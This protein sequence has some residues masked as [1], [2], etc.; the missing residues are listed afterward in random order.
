MVIG[1]QMLRIL[2]YFPVYLIFWDF[3]RF[4]DAFADE[5]GDLRMK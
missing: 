3:R 5:F 1:L 4:A 2:L